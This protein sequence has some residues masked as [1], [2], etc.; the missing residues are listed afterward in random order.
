MPRAAGAH[1]YPGSDSTGQEMILQ[2]APV[3][4][5]QGPAQSTVQHLKQKRFNVPFPFLSGWLACRVSRVVYT[6]PHAKGETEAWRARPETAHRVI[7]TARTAQSS[8]WAGFNRSQGLWNLSSVRLCES[9]KDGPI[10][11]MSRLR[12][13]VVFLIHYLEVRFQSSS[14]WLHWKML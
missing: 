7:I 5:K 4:G 6:F 12:L 8:S 9:W 2:D 3:H 11:L 14:R 1:L 10:M 13:G